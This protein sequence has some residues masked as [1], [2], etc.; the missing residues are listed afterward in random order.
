LRYGAILAVLL[1]IRVVYWWQGRQLKQPAGMAKNR[2][3]AAAQ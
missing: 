3:A 2:E 1:I